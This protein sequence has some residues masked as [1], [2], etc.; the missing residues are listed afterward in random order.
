MYEGES[1]WEAVADL[2]YMVVL[3]KVNES[4]VTGSHFSSLT[5]SGIYSV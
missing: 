4:W 1:G 5:V 3:E 2:L